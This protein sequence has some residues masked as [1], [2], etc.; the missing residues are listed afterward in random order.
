MAFMREQNAL[1]DLII[2]HLQIY[3]NQDKPGH[4][5]AMFK[6]RLEGPSSQ[7]R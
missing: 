7:S 1:L 3:L 2:D 4:R 5:N 6:A